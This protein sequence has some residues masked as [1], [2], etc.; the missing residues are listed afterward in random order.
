MLILE[1]VLLVLIG[2]FIADYMLQNDWM[3]LNKKD[4]ILPLLV[5]CTI[6]TVTVYL[7]LLYYLLPLKWFFHPLTLIVIFVSHI[8]LDGTHLIDKFF[9]LTGGR[10]WDIAIT[11]IKQMTDLQDKV[12]Y[13]LV[14]YLA[15]T[16]LVQTVIDNVLHLIMIL[17]YC[18]YI[19]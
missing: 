2:H 10:S 17:M 6:Y 3:A 16:C 1:I 5:H 14:V 13:R 4:K 11:K 7:C 15:Y 19:F 12:D 9:N 18:Y 8:I